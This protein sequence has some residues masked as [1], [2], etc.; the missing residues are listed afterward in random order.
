MRRSSQ[1]DRHVEPSL[2]TVQ[3]QFTDLVAIRQKFIRQILG[4][5]PFKTSYFA[6]YRVLDDAG[7]RTILLMGI[8]LAMAAGTPYVE[9]FEHCQPHTNES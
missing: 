6:L 9:C 4:L 8:L 7:S 1:W 3:P 5:N 2:A